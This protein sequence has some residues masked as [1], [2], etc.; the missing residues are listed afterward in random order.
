MS[1][2]LGNLS[3]A[4]MER[5]LGI[6]LDT[7]EREVLEGMRQDKASNI[8]PGKIHCFDIPFMIVCGCMDTAI[9]VRDILTPY[10]PQMTTAIQIGI[11]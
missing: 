6:M 11:D 10:S 2:A 9:K 5:R 4:D 1:I 3:I 8:A 7:N